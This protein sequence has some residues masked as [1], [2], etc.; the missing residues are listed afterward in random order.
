MTG[1]VFNLNFL[2]T[3]TSRCIYLF[4][5]TPEDVYTVVGSTRICVQSLLIRAEYPIPI[6]TTSLH[7]HAAGHGSAGR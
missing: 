2:A 3:K 6:Q 5:P 1:S 7:I 4:V